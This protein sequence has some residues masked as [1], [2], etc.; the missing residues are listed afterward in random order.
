MNSR[1]IFTSAKVLPWHSSQMALPFNHKISGRA[2]ALVGSR[3][4]IIIGNPIIAKIIINSLHF[5]HTKDRMILHAYVIMEN[6]IHLIASS[7]A[8]FTS[9][10]IRVTLDT[11]LMQFILHPTFIYYF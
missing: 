1:C 6:H 11:R 8:D 7:S 10:K 5:L 4:R 2:L 9:W 3:V